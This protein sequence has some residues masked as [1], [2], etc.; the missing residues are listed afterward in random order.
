MR[1]GGSRRRQFV[2]AGSQLHIRQQETK[3]AELSRDSKKPE[4]A[5][6]DLFTGGP[7]D[8]QPGDLARHYDNG[9]RIGVIGGVVGKMARVTDI[10]GKKRPK[11]VPL[12]DLAKVPPVKN[13]STEV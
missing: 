3:D 5:S 10:L 8:F 9:W 11:L 6:L 4:L 7:N 12:V 2:F 1:D 13:L